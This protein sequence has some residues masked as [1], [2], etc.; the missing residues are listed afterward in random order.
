[1]GDTVLERNLCFVDTP[2]YS[3]K[4][5][6]KECI[7]LVVNYVEA[8]S[9]KASSFASMDDGELV[10]ILSGKGGTQVD[11]VF[12]LIAQGTFPYLGYIGSADSC[13][14]DHTARL[15]FHK[16]VI[17]SYKCDTTNSKSRFLVTRR[18]SV[19]EDVYHKRASIRPDKVFHVQP[20]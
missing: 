9:S 8:Q 6:T 13:S 15:E 17:G 2:G 14:S 10:S 1:M 7:N 12:Y 19:F 3:H 18:S 5:S 20:S 4:M 11:L 16:T